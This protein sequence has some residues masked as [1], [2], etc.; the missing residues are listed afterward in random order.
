MANQDKQGGKIYVCQKWPFTKGRYWLCSL[1]YADKC[2]NMAA[3]N[4]LC[5]TVINL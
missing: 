1:H 4:N 5:I 2:D 3:V